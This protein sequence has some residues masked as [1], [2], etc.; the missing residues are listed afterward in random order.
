MWRAGVERGRTQR[1]ART[2]DAHAGNEIGETV[3]ADRAI[4]IASF[5]GKRVCE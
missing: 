2:R 5:P 4:R 3:V 1:T